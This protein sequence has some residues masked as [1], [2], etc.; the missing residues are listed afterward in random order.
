MASRKTLHLDEFTPYGTTDGL[1]FKMNG[2]DDMRGINLRRAMYDLREWCIGQGCR[3]QAEIAMS[4]IDLTC[5]GSRVH[6]VIIARSFQYDEA[7]DTEMI[8]KICRPAYNGLVRKL[9]G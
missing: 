4:Y 6:L 8:R 3:E 7:V 5:A 9:G 2:N 1:A